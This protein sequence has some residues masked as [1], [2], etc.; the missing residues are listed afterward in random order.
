MYQK[1][2]QEQRKR[3]W[4]KLYTFLSIHFNLFPVRRLKKEQ[5]ILLQPILGNFIF[6]KVLSVFLSVLELLPYCCE[7]NLSES[8][9]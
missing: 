7:F 4:V 1:K 8:T 9:T 2:K 5:N 3:F 6:F